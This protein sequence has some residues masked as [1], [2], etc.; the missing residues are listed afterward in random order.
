MALGTNENQVT[1]RY[2]FL[3]NKLR[4]LNTQKMCVLRENWVAKSK[5]IIWQQNIYK[6]LTNK[7]RIS[8]D[9]IHTAFFFARDFIKAINLFL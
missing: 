6:I 8:L 4:L 5:V 9:Y 3:N 7:E 1:K 2:T